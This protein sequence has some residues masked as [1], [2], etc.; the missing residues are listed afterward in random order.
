M[1]RSVFPEET[2]KITTSWVELALT[3]IFVLLAGSAL[4]QSDACKN[5][6]DLDAQYCDENKDLVA[7]TPKDP[8]RYKT[9]NT[10]VFTYTPVEDPAVYEQA[11]R[12]FT[13]HLAKCTSKKVVF[14][15][16]QSNAAEIE[17]MRS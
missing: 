16:V 17:A 1:R 5:R 8:K 2:M 10:L 15:Q 9:P 6:G 14:F 11:F 12:P 4:A 7:D 13:D 3:A